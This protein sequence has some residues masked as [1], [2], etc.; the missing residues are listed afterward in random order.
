M[1]NNAALTTSRPAVLAD[2]FPAVPLREAALVVG[3]A[4][5]VGL[6]AQISIPLPWT[7]VPLTLQTFGVLLSGAILGARRGV[8]AMS[9]YA[10]AGLMGVPWFSPPHRTH[11][12]ALWGYIVGF[13]LAAGLAGAWAERGQDRRPLAA[14]GTFF[15]ADLSIYAVG[16]PWLALGL[17]L[18]ARQTYTLG[19]EPFLGGDALKAI[20]AAGLLPGAWRL[21]GPKKISPPKD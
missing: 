21:F 12:G 16:L 8:A 4:G 11:P 13:I 20:V 3:A 6:C 19:M 5:F 2:L 1:S 18:S 14:L 15:V 7:P 10:L 9:L 17:H